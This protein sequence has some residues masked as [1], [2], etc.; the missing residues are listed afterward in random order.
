M[1]RN[2]YKQKMIEAIE[3]YYESLENDES[4]YK[5]AGEKD[6]EELVKWSI[7]EKG[8]DLDEMTEVLHKKVFPFRVKGA[9]PKNFA[10]IPSPASDISKIGDIITTLYNPNGAGWFSAPLVT[11]LE[12]DVIDWLCEKVGYGKEAG[13]IFVSGGS[14]SNLTG[15]IAARDNVLGVENILK[16]VAYVSDQAHHSVNKG[17]RMAGIPDERIHKVRT[18]ENLKMIPEDLEELILK[19]KE[20]GLIPFIVAGTAGTT[21][22]G[23]I[24]PLFELSK[25]AKKYGLWFHV[26]AAFGGSLLLSQ[27]YSGN[28][29]GIEEADSVTWDGH[30]WLFQTYSCAMILAKDKKTLLKSFSD[31]PSYLKDAQSQD[32]I[33]SWDLGPDLS[34]PSIGI[35][36]WLTLQ[37]IGTDEMGRRIEHGVV[38]AEKI[39]KELRK[40]GHWE[41]VTPAQQAILNFGYYSKEKSRDELDEINLKISQKFVD[42]GKSNILTTEVKGK[43]VLR[44]C[45]IS[46]DITD[47]DIVEVVEYLN[48]YIMEFK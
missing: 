23:T 28:L 43:K 26:D 15:I 8:R 20:Q 25:V 7:P 11:Q 48:E 13:G 45:S 47:K 19:D 37:T 42:S 40:Y 1:D 27:R 5:K 14:Q 41:I 18:D 10:F 16:G 29:K 33:E 17:L 35:K 4:T 3:S 38:M 34:R 39:E 36:L 24:D 21:N 46:P 12:N 22:S 2:Y 9:Q 32:R 30:K 44:I 6:F 31:D